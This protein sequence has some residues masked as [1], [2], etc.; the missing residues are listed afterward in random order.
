MVITILLTLSVFL[1]AV[2]LLLYFAA[3]TQFLHQNKELLALYAEQYENNPNRKDG[4]PKEGETPYPIPSDLPS[5]NNNPVPLPNEPPNSKNEHILSISAIYS[6]SFSLNGEVME[7]S[8][9]TKGFSD[10]E[11]FIEEARKL[12]DRYHDT[13]VHQ[14]FT[15]GTYAN[16]VYR[17]TATKDYTLVSFLDTTLSDEHLNSLARETM[18]II[19]LG[20]LILVPLVFFFAGRII[21][22]L[23]END[24]R[25]KQFISDA[26]HELKTPVT[27]ISANVELLSRDIPHNEWLNSIQY[28]NEKMSHLIIELLD[29]SRAETMKAPMERLDFSRLI[30]GELLPFESLA[31]EQERLITSQINEEIFVEGNKDHLGRLTSILLDNALHH[32]KGEGDILLTLTTDH[33]K[34]RLTVSNPSDPIPED[35]L[36]HLFERFYRADESRTDAGG[37]RHYGLGLAIAKAI[38]EEH[39][40]EIRVDCQDKRVSFTVLLPLKSH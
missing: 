15:S 38:V 16:Y 12:Y 27:V 10:Q 2:L 25:Q 5:G 37:A 26:G 23:E 20:L 17:I 24:R 13:K 35:Q 29:L 31:F 34:A 36:P 7:A 19:L 3:K 8:L 40:G 22:P 32:A 28:E 14:G 6:V 30:T 21:K 1:T 33:H 39:R 11:A 9:S 4:T 18:I